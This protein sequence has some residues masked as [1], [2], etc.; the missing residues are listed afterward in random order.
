MV[1]DMERAETRIAPVAPLKRNR[2]PKFG[3][4][5]VLAGVF[6]CAL[7]YVLYGQSHV[8]TYQL[9]FS[10]ISDVNFKEETPR[11]AELIVEYAN[12]T[13][14]KLIDNRYASAFL[15]ARSSHWFG[16][17][18]P[19]SRF[20]FLPA[21][22]GHR[23]AIT[24]VLARQSN[25]SRAIALPLTDLTP[26]RQVE[27][28]EKKPDWLL[29]RTLPGTEAPAV[30]LKPTAPLDFSTNQSSFLSWT[31]PAFTLFAGAAF[32]LVI[33]FRKNRSLDLGEIS[34][35]QAAQFG[36]ATALVLAMAIVS[37]FNSNP[38]EYL[39]FEASK[40]FSINWISPALDDPAVEPSFSHYGVSYLQDLDGAYLFIGKLMAMI[41]SWVAGQEVAARLCNV[42]LFVLLAAWMMRRLPNSFASAILLIS[43]QI[44]YVFSYVNSDAWALALSLI[45]VVQMATTDSL[46]SQYLTANN[47]QS[48]W[49][50]GL[51]FA[52]LIA[53]LLMAKRNY[54][55]FLPFIGL[56]AIWQACV[57]SKEISPLR[58]ISRWAMIGVVALTMYLPFRVGHEALNRFDSAGIRLEQAEKFAAPKFKPSEIAAGKG[59][60]RLALRQQ[61]VGYAELFIGHN[62][63][64][65]SFQSFCGVYQWMSLRSPSEYYFA[66]SLLYLALLAFLVMA[67]CRVSRTDAIF[68][69]ATLGVAI[70]LVLLSAY[71]SWTADFQPQGRYLFPVLPLIAYLFHRYREYLQSRV[72]NLLLAGLFA[73]SI[74][75]FV[76]IGLKNIPK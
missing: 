67:I 22:A 49:R 27:V 63:A 21:P 68:A 16:I 20:L 10:I 15:D 64:L 53:L 13:T 70:C 40:Y 54:Y 76:F 42:L 4:I 50:G 72:F 18:N 28:L 17:S 41:P 35:V 74:Y 36:A 3:T 46:L 69:L 5:I 44:W 34:G 32:L 57:W 59:V 60:Q 12:G 45:V 11:T 19:P 38:D 62:W 6:I 65:Q 75:S 26:F 61:G 8:P 47:W 73:G 58:L 48:A 14:E 31:V 23:V 39:H 2:Q 7:I 30:E 56:V 33:A 24:Q 55:V 43:P 25:G 9:Q 29:L 52:T 66:M 51:W 37:K 71:Q 1:L